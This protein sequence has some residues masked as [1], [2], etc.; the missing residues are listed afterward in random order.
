MPATWT[1]T[2]LPPGAILTAPSD[3]TIVR[4]R[5]VGASGGPFR[6]RVLT[7]DGET[8]Y[9]G[10]GTGPAQNPTTS[11]TQTF[12]A[13]LPIRTGQIVGFDNTGT[14]DTFASM[15]APGATYTDWNPPLA[16]SSTLPYTNPYGADYEIAFN[17]DVRYCVVP[18]LAGKKVGAAKRAL[19]AADCALGEIVRP[20]KKARRKKAKFVRAESVAAGIS[21]SDTAPIALTLGKKHKHR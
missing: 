2:V 4:W 5:I 6:L 7:P 18:A 19:A 11:G 14:M 20:Q 9:T 16:D 3:G 8:T 15:A 10:A 21:I 12:P 17:A 1:N 13:S